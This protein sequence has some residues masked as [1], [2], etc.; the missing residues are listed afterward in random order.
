MADRIG[1]GFV[2]WPKAVLGVPTALAFDFGLKM[3]MLYRSCCLLFHRC[4]DVLSSHK[5]TVFSDP[6][7]DKRFLSVLDFAALS[8]N[9]G[10]FLVVPSAVMFCC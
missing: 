6:C 9:G 10:R 5:K 2:V 1:K 7:I 8:N 4:E 3:R